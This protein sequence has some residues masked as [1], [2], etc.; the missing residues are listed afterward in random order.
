MT[1][2]VFATRNGKVVKD[3]LINERIVGDKVIITGHVGKK[4]INMRK[5]LRKSLKSLRKSLRKSLK[6]I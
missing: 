1:K 6:S 3:E 4:K 5:S 2:S